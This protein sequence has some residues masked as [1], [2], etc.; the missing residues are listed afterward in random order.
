MTKEFSICGV[1]GSA[2][3]ELAPDL[4]YPADKADGAAFELVIFDATGVLTTALSLSG[5]FKID[6]LHLDGLTVDDL[7][8]VKLTIDGVVI[9]N[10][11]LSTNLTSEPLIG[12]DLTSGY[13]PIVCDTSL[14]LEVRTTADTTTQL[15][16]IARPIL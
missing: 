15:K 2:L 4:T 8:E 9:W 12:G 16:F 14:L 10:T 5:K 1:V 6:L 3:A 7:D 11:T 13:E